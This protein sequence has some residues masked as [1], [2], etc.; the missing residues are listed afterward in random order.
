MEMML[1]ENQIEKGQK[2]QY[3]RGE[4]YTNRYDSVQ[5]NYGV[6]DTWDKCLNNDGRKK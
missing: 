1:S 4:M 5:T 3:T 6:T 2:Q